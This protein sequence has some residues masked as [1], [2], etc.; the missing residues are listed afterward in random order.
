MEGKSDGK[1][2]EIR[3]TKLMNDDFG[4]FFSGIS[5]GFEVENQGTS[6]YLRLWHSGLHGK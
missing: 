1:Y 6:S 3:G 4:G 2:L 5:K